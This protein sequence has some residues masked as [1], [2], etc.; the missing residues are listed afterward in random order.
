MRAGW[1][2][3]RCCTDCC[4]VSCSVIDVAATGT[5][6]WS[7]L[8]TLLSSQ[9]AATSLMLHLPR[10]THTSATRCMG[11]SRTSTRTWLIWWPPASDTPAA[12]LPTVSAPSGKQECRFGYPKSLQPNTAIVTEEEPTLI[13]AR[14][15]GMINSFN[16]VQLS[17]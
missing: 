11:M 16:P 12:P 4:T 9:T 14:N 5:N 6:D 2:Y 17:A 10:S 13:T 8:S 3:W 15:D 1:E 7:P